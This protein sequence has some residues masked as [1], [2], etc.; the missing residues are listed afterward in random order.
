MYLW[1]VG[2]N[3]LMRILIMLKEIEDAVL[4]HQARDKVESGLPVLHDVFALWV[5]ALGTVLE[6]LK[7]VILED[8]L[9]D[10]G[11]CLLLENLAIGSAGEKP[12][13]RDD[14]RLVV[15]KAIV[16]AGRCETAYKAIP[17]ALVIANLLNGESY[18][19]TDNVFKRDGM[20][21]G[22]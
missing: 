3:Q 1:C 14:F 6:V 2:E 18:L 19:L 11:N 17:M 15:A 10:F 20:I 12:E 13:P 21:F 7:A 8:F 22:Q 5:G 9:D 4:L 16:A